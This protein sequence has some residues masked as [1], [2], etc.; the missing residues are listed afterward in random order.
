[1][2]KLDHIQ[3]IITKKLIQNKI[4][5]FIL[6]NSQEIDSSILTDWTIDII[7]EYFFN[8]N[9][10]TISSENNPDILFIRDE[11]YLQKKFYD[12]SFLTDISQFSSHKSLSGDKKFII[13]ENLK[14]LSENHMN[15]LLKTLEEPPVPMHILI[16]NSDG[17]RPLLTISSRSISINCPLTGKDLNKANDKLLAKFQDY[18]MYRFIE[19]CKKTKDSE[20]NIARYILDN[21]HSLSNISLIESINN[22]LKA[23]AHDYEYNYSPNYRLTQLYN[24]FQIIK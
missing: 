18:P 12:K 8:L 3:K 22:Y 19:E 2:S 4:S 16:L 14:Y 15:K 11:K 20:E 9:Q 21:A 7:N 10:R 5:H 17:V 23:K 13:I 1:M 6:I 24:A